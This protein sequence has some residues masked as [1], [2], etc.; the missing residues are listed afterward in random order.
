MELLQSLGFCCSYEEVL[1]FER[2]SATSFNI[3]IPVE[4]NSFVQYV[5]EN[6]D[7]NLCTLDGRGT[8]HG[9]GIIAAVANSSK[10]KYP[11]ISRVKV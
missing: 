1:K 11:L 9:M 6:A 2:S 3:E 10:R 7:H 5:A 4:A 8:F